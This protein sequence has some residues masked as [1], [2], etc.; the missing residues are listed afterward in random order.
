MRNYQVS[1]LS[2]MNV[3][4]KPCNVSDMI[5]NHWIFNALAGIHLFQTATKPIIEKNNNTGQN[6][7][8]P[9]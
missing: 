4:I 5:I 9:L 1:K 8:P 6:L 3:S 7:L 2:F